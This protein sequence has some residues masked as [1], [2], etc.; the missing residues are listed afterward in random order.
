MNTDGKVSVIMLTYNRENMVERAIKSI[1]AQNYKNF[2]LILV[3]NGSEDNSGKICD[4]FKALDRRVSVVHSPKGNIGTGRNIGI[5]LARGDYITFIDDDDYAYEDML[6]FL[7][8]LIEEHDADIA[9]CGS[10]KEINGT[11]MDNYVYD[12]CKIMN[13]QEGVIEYLKRQLFNAAMPTKLL[14]KELFLK[15]RFFEEGNYD[16]IVV[17]YRL[18]AEAKK[19]V[20][21]GI[22]KYCFVRHSGNNS[23]AAVS[24]HLLQPEQLDEYFQAFRDRTEFLSKKLPEIADYALYSEW[25][26]LISMCNKI[27]SNSLTSCQKQLDYIHKILKA[28]YN[29]FYNSPYIMEF[30]KEFMRKYIK[31]GKD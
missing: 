7:M 8:K 1:L 19:I 23:K 27:T 24:D 13:T 6:S 4:R 18:F 12:N 31:V 25:S 10:H 15:H 30:E 3:D 11:I 2:E 21:H 9:L 26:Y 5:D 22:P 29:Q 16:D 14:K 17:G 28:N 20:A